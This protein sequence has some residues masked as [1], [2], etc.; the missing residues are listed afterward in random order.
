[1]YLA[2]LMAH[3]PYCIQSY[4]LS[5]DALEPEVTDHRVDNVEALAG[6]IMLSFFREDSG[7]TWQPPPGSVKKKA[8]PMTIGESG[9]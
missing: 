4:R 2:G 5:N 1:M 6:W 9:G 3:V 8:C 7:T